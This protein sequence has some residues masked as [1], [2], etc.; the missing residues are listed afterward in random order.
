MSDCAWRSCK[1][2]IKRGFLSER[3]AE[4]ALGRAQ[5]KRNRKSDLIGTRRGQHIEQRFYECDE[6]L[7]HL[8]S[9]NR[10]SY[11]SR[12]AYRIDTRF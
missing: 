6:G 1:C 2:G 9:E 3:D 7:F 5:S 11:E 4:K 8:T 10:S 12:N